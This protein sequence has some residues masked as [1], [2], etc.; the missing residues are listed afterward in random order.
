MSEH[1]YD[2]IYDSLFTEFIALLQR[3]N[4]IDSTTTNILISPIISD[5]EKRYKKQFHEDLHPRMWSIE[6]KENGQFRVAVSNLTPTKLDELTQKLSD[7]EISNLRFD[8]ELY[9]PDLGVIYE[10]AGI[11]RKHNYVFSAYWALD[12]STFSKH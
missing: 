10:K 9:D 3:E 12:T 6:L 4:S 8:S 5:I 1:L 11:K 7:E 2:L